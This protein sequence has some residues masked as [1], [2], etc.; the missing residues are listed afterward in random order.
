MFC[1]DICLKSQRNELSMVWLDYLMTTVKV[2]TSFTNKFDLFESLFHL[3]QWWYDEK[4]G[5]PISMNEMAE[6]NKCL[7]QSAD[8]RGYRLPS[9]LPHKRS[10]HLPARCVI[11]PLSVLSWVH[12]TLSA[13]LSLSLVDKINGVGGATPVPDAVSYRVILWWT[14]KVREVSCV[15]STVK[16]GDMSAYIIAS[17]SLHAHV[18]PS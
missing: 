7:L 2:R 11:S 3:L 9:F 13:S 14:G 1:H 12:S 5:A 17:F 18:F 8:C 16:S 10:N 4:K 6:S 15:R